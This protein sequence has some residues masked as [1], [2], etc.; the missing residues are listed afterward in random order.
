M[1]LFAI[2]TGPTVAQTEV[3]IM[4]Q[5][6]VE[7]ARERGCDQVADFYARPG[8]VYAPYV[9]GIVPGREDDSVAF[10]CQRRGGDGRMNYILVLDLAF[11]REPLGDCPA[12]IETTNYPGA[13]TMRKL[14]DLKLRN[15]VY[16]RDTSKRGPNIALTHPSI[17]STYDG[18]GDAYYC[19]RGEWLVIFLH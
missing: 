18:T 16:V 3:L 2:R 10:W 7:K 4:P 14:R 6:L 1:L 11:K 17:I 9:Y 13:L 19:H 8:P 15:F 5:D 12:M